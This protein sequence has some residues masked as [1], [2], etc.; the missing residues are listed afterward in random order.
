LFD[1][2]SKH[3]EL[4]DITAAKRFDFLD[5]IIFD[6]PGNYLPWQ[7]SSSQLTQLFMQCKLTDKLLFAAG[8]GMAQLAYFCAM[9]SR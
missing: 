3:G 4:S 1:D 8:C 2:N 5:F 9:E 6:V 7:D